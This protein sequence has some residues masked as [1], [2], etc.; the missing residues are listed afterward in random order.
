MMHKGKMALSGVCEAEVTL[1]LKGSYIYCTGTVELDYYG[2]DSL[3]CHDNS[4]G[5]EMESMTQPL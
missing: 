3:T 1:R 2:L 5:K 4:T